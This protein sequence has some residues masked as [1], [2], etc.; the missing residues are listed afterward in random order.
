[1]RPYSTSQIHSFDVDRAEAPEL[2]R[3]TRRLHRGVPVEKRFW[4][5]VQ[6]TSSCW[7]WTGGTTGKSNYGQIGVNGHHVLAHRFA[8]ELLV[9]PIPDGLELDHLCRT[10][11]CVNPDHL[12]V[13]TGRVNQLRGL[14]PELNRTRAKLITQ[15]PNGHLY[16]EANTYRGPAGGGRQCRTCHIEKQRQRRAAAR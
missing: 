12:E 2:I 3:G 16:D 13:V 9:G 5:Q 4:M 8:Y 7:L 10:H 6:K 1:M 11:P 14:N 15:C